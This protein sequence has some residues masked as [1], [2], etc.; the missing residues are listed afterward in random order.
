MRTRQEIYASRG[1]ERKRMD[2]ERRMEK[3][4][5]V[6]RKGR[7]GCIVEQVRR[8]RREI[9]TVRVDEERSERDE[10]G[11]GGRASGVATGSG[12]TP[13]VDFN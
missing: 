12:P 7:E 10:R 9:K 5:K 6:V 1:R 8:L 11:R 2:T 4:G 13:G 3:A